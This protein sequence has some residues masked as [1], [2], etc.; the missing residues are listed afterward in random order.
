MSTTRVQFALT[1]L[2]LL[3]SSCAATSL[4][5]PP[6][7]VAN[8]QAHTMPVASKALPLHDDY[9]PWEGSE[10][11]AS[12]GHGAHAGHETQEGHA[13]EKPAAPEKDSAAPEPATP[14]HGGHDDE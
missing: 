13:P 6:E 2:L 12:A 5:V 3:A 8:P 10:N 11:D 4:D 7:S 1:A 9:D 14:A